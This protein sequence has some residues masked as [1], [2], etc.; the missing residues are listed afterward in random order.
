MPDPEFFFNQTPPNMVEVEPI[1][2]PGIHWRDDGNMTIYTSYG[3]D[4]YNS[5]RIYEGCKECYHFSMVFG[6][7][8]YAKTH[9]KIKT[10]EDFEIVKSDFVEHFNKAHPDLVAKKRTVKPVKKKFE[11]VKQ[12]NTFMFSPDE[13]TITYM[14]YALDLNTQ[15]DLRSLSN[16]LVEERHGGFRSRRTNRYEV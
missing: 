11:K 12:N 13:A 8:I 10:E 6:G 4:N 15:R 16:Q 5:S 2:L 1:T 14:D 7:D 3:Q 9:K